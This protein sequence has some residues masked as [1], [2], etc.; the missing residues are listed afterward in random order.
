MSER[1]P[2]CDVT[3]FSQRWIIGY[4]HYKVFSHGRRPNCVSNNDIRR[5]L[6]ATVLKKSKLSYKEKPYKLSFKRAK[7]LITSED[8]A[9]DAIVVEPLSQT[10]SFWMVH[11]TLG[12]TL[13]DTSD[14][15]NC[16]PWKQVTLTNMRHCLRGSSL[17]YVRSS[18]SNC[19]IEKSL[20]KGF[21]G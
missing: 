6:K 3:F 21:L 17:S 2:Q 10:T 18:P 5:T 9:E 16:E 1:G 4:L 20:L 8:K 14:I 19:Q 11:I 15:L 12:W 13:C 7:L